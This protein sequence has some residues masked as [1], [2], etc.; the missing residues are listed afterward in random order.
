MTLDETLANKNETTNK[1]VATALRHAGYFGIGFAVGVV[2]E[3]V[4]YEHSNVSIVMGSAFSGGL[5]VGSE[6]SAQRRLKGNLSFLQCW[7]YSFSTVPATLGGT[8]AGMYMA[9]G[10]K[11]L[12]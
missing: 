1:G 5:N 6:C 2:V 9:R 4:G 8:F 3:M 10:L 12:M 7:G 11:N